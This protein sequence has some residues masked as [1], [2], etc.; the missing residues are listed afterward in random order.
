[1]T[2]SFL[3]PFFAVLLAVLPRATAHACWDGYAVRQGDIAFTGGDETWDAASARDLATW[4]LRLQALLGPTGTV[5]AEFGFGEAC[6]GDRCVELTGHAHTPRALFDDVARALAIPAAQRAA[7]LRITAEPYAVQVAATH[8]G[9]AAE[10]LAA[11]ISQGDL[12]IGF[13]EAG[14]FP[15]DNPEAHVVKAHDASGAV[16]FRVVVGAFVDRADASAHAA[17]IATATG[18]PTLLRKL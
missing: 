18:L 13:Y 2:R 15:A 16:I 12:P 11:R 6:I 3:L 1:M 9:A 17:E 7:A 5:E 8:D 10:T 14:G 4:T